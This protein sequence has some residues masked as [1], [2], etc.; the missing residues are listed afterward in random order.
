MIFRV[1][2]FFDSGEIKEMK[3]IRSGGVYGRKKYIRKLM[4]R[5]LFVLGYVVFVCD[6]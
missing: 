4:W 3:E 5:S 2:E 1:R 6:C